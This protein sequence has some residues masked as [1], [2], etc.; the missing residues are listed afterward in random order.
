MKKYCATGIACLLF[1]LCASAQDCSNYLFL[2]KNKTIENTIYNKKGDAMGRQV[3]TVTDV[4]SA[5]GIVSGNLSSEMFDK[6][7]KSM[8]KASSTVRCNGGVMMIDM[9]MLMPQQQQQQFDGKMEAKADDIYIEYPLGMKA[10]DMLKDGNMTL[11]TSNHGMQQTI[12][13]QMYERKVEAQ[14]QVTTPAGTW[15]CF[16]ISYKCKMGVKMGP[17]NVPMNFDGIEWYAP[18]VGVIK[19]ESKYGSTMITSIK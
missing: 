15:N 13:M 8:A 2:Q 10:G 12:S 6:N 17:I 11:T 5:G 1:A 3:Y 16:K 9:K 4:T 7:N 19:T 14:E 18:G